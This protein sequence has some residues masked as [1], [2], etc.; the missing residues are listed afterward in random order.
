[1]WMIRAI[2]FLVDHERA[3][4]QRF[5]FDVAVRHSEQFGEIVQ[6]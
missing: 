2:A 4:H 6:G 5:G 1:M 3:P